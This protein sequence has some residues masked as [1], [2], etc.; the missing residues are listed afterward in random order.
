M[1][2][3]IIFLFLAISL[4]CTRSK[5]TNDSETINYPKDINFMQIKY[6]NP[7]EVKN[8]SLDQIKEKY[9]PLEE[10]DFLLNKG[11]RSEFRIELYNFF[12][13]KEREKPI[14]IKEVTWEKDQNTNYTVWYKKEADHWVFIYSYIWNKNQLF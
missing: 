2:I 11:L 5:Q 6:I 10:E 3:I 13:E 1:K 14:M 9:K 12:N 4:S 8:W 7:E